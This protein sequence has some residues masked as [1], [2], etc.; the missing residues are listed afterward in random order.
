L[1]EELPDRWRQNSRAVGVDDREHNQPPYGTAK[2]TLARSGA[3]EYVQWAGHI[4]YGIRPSARRRGL[5]T[6]AMIQLLDEA[7][8]LDLRR[9]LAVCAVDNA[10]SIKT[11]ERCGGEFDGIRDTKFGH[12]VRRY[13]ID[14]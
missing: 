7:R 3:A 1:I 6:W 12:P 4:G 8:R 11:I 14:L 5:A 2:M 9:V 10:A 13:W